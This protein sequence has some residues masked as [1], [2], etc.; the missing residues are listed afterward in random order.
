MYPKE[1]KESKRSKKI[2]KDSKWFQK[3]PEK[4]FTKEYTAQILGQPNCS[5]KG[6]FNHRVEFLDKPQ[7]FLM[8]FWVFQKF[9]RVFSDE[10]KN[11]PDPLQANTSLT[12]ILGVYHRRWKDRSG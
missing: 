1:S 3:I 4:R 8:D 10:I 7:V 11:H 6:F 12:H 2:P 5:K 9:E